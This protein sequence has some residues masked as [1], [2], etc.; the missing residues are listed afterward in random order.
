MRNILL[1]LLLGSSLFATSIQI[2]PET[3]CIRKGGT[4]TVDVIVGSVE[5]LG[6]A[7]LI[8]NFDPNKIKVIATPTVG[9]LLTEMGWMEP[10][11]GDGY[12]KVSGVRFPPTGT[13]GTGSI[14]EDIIFEAK[15]GD[16]TSYLT[17]D[18]IQLIHFPD[19]ET[20]T[21]DYI[22]SSSIFAYPLSHFNLIASSTAIAGLPFNL[23][24]APIDI[25]GSPS[26]AYQGTVNLTVDNGS[27]SPASISGFSEGSLTTNITLTK[28]GTTTITAKNLM[29]TQ[30]G[31]ATVY[32][33]PGSPT[34]FSL[35]PQA[36]S[37]TS[38]DSLAFT[39][40]IKD[41]NGNTWTVASA[42]IE[43]DPIGTMTANTYYP[44]KVG[45]WTI[46]ATYTTFSAT[47]T[48]YV[49]Q[50]SS[51]A[52]SL[53]PQAASLTIDDS[54]AF[55]AFV[56]DNDGNTQ[57]VTGSVTF[58]TN[59][60]TMT[61]NVYYPGKAGTWTIT[62]TYTTFMA[63][64]IVV[65]CGRLASLAIGVIGDQI[66]NV[67]FPI[68]ISAS[69]NKGEP[70]WTGATLTD[71]S[72]TIH[73]ILITVPGTYTGYVT[74]A[75]PGTTSITVLSGTISATSNPF[76][77]ENVFLPT[78]LDDIRVWPNPYRSDR[79]SDQF[80]VFELPSGCHLCIYT[81][82]GRLIREFEKTAGRV[83]WMLDNQD[84]EPVSSG[85]Y[86]YLIEQAGRKVTGEVGVI[87]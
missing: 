20:I 71:T 72:G 80:I 53:Q 86:I 64:A 41:S 36:A 24:I 14:A 70:I 44:G 51:I 81:I 9:S 23:I 25:E 10:E 7:N 46:T 33:I 22:G 56:R 68:T 29:G 58:T 4:F 75:K 31:T 32:V 37:L 17:F 5:D 78:G 11:I 57:T 43:N 60:G 55:I 16:P 79:S 8:L 19:Y 52:F 42:F 76:F 47:A 6:G 35:Q 62:A 85:M 84:G 21:V 48:I 77:V 73:P 66:T 65:V 74:I 1:A 54:L 34:A 39:T 18:L 40:F 50:G 15:A 13:S 30:T 27:I 59:G 3:V 61:A 12:V 69:D 45:T 67:S 38:D 83:K 2:K 87:K 82:S 49:T 28:S 63:Q 26:L